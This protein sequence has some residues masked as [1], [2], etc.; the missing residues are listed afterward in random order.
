MPKTPKE[1]CKEV[2][3]LPDSEDLWSED[4][5]NRQYYYD[6]AHGYETYKPEND[7]DEDNDGEPK[8]K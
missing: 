7:C 1:D 3:E 8:E 6:D 5:K 4:Q 2:K